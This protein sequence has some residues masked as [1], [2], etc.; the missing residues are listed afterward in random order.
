LFIHHRRVNR[1]GRIDNPAANSEKTTNLPADDQQI[2][3]PASRPAPA[4]TSAQQT[5][6]NNTMKQTPIGIAMSGGVDS[7]ACA[8]LL[9]REHQVHGFLMN[10]GQPG[11]TQQQLQ[12]AAIARRLDIDVT[13]VDLRQAFARLVL[14]YFSA[15]YR[16]G[17]TPN[18]CMI[19][20][21]TI[22]FGLFME[23]IQAGGCRTMATG[24]YA[25]TALI[26]G[27]TALLRGLDRSKDQS[28]FLARLRPQQLTQVLFPLGSMLKDDTYRL[29]EAQGFTGFRGKESQDICFL[30]DT[31]IAD[32]LA[33]GNAPPTEPGPIVTVDGEQIGLHHG[34]LHYT[35]GQRRGIGLPDQSPWY[36]TAIDPA[37]NTLV[38]GKSGDLLQT[39]L[40]ARQASWLT[41]TPPRTGDRFLV[42]IRYTHKGSE[43]VIEG[44]DDD[45]FSLHFN[46]PQRAVAPGQF[47]VLYDKERVIGS[48][49]IGRPPGMTSE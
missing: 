23:A 34:L 37:T 46:E 5:A 21:H 28:Y 35:I 26:T 43:A 45:S 22:K 42:Q 14:D 20:N 30:K 16:T 36:V 29:V 11:F 12:V 48:G 44:I 3:I 33:A 7:T 8:L 27:E 2:S 6:R 49:E 24:H 13:I 25:R 38:V 1:Q 19:C 32:H 18:P 4:T 40:R 41:A 47:A 31:T 15:T 39:R 10:I 9:R 17:M